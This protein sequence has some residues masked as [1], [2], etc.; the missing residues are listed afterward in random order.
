MSFALIAALGQ[1]KTQDGMIA[2]Q[3]QS[4]AHQITAALDWWREAGVDCDYLSEPRQWI[5][6]AEEMPEPGARVRQQ[7]EPAPP[8]RELVPAAPVAEAIGGDPAGW[9]RDLAAFAQWWLAEPVLDNGMVMDRV[10]PRGIKGA[11]LMVLVAEPEAGDRERLLSGPQG[12]L[13]ASML[14]AMGVAEDQAYIASVLPRR[15]PAA[16]WPALSAAG[17]GQVLRHH[18]D[19]A[20]PQR[21][22]VCGGNILPLVGNDLPNSA[23]PSRRINQGGRNVPLLAAPD[24]QALLARPRAKAALWRNWLEWTASLT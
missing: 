9:P 7:A 20:A 2:P 15:M 11:A 6:P 12:K 8:S 21:L 18:L 4:I 3:E 23:E 17:I 16:D 14:R 5:T 19:L 10:P 22:I 1:V 13:L 24:L